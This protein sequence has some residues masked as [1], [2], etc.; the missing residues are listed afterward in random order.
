MLKSLLSALKESVRFIHRQLTDSLSGSPGVDKL[1][2]ERFITPDAPA[3]SSN[4]GAH[5]VSSRTTTSLFELLH[6]ICPV[7]GSDR[8]TREGFAEFIEVPFRSVRPDP[9]AADCKELAET[10]PECR[11]LFVCKT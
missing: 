4:E 11:V 10:W 9:E 8:A 5:S 2:P 7:C 1:L 3:S 6:P